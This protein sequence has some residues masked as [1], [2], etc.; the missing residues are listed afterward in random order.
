MQGDHA[1]RNT[2]SGG[3]TGKATA[4]HDF[5][6]DPHVVEAVHKALRSLCN[7]EW[8]IRSERYYPKSMQG[9]LCQQIAEELRKRMAD[10]PSLVDVHLQQEL[11]APELQQ[12]KEGHAPTADY[13]A[14]ASWTSM[15]R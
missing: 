15:P 6:E 4:F 9:P 3:G 7:I 13:M 8:F 2:E 11:D 14:R 1:R 10:I 12:L 5:R